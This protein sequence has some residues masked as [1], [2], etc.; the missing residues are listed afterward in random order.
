LLKGQ[1]GFLY[2]DGRQL[3]PV[4]NA[5]THRRL[6]HNLMR[7]VVDRPGISGHPTAR[8]HTRDDDV[9]ALAAE[10]VGFDGGRVGYIAEPHFD[11]VGQSRGRRAHEAH[12]VVPTGPQLIENRSADGA[13]GSQQQHAPGQVRSGEIR[14]H[15]Y[16]GS[17]EIRRPPA[18]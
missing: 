3:H 13:G 16:P 11:T 8:G 14:L 15:F 17:A 2:A 18:P 5:M 7:A 9:E 1:P 6:K 12:H 10:A 4:P